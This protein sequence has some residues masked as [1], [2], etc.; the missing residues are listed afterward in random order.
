MNPGFSIE[1]AIPAYNSGRGIL[2]TLYSISRATAELGL[3]APSLVL[4]DSSETTDTVDAAARWAEETGASLRVDRS[5][6]RRGIKEATNVAFDLARADVLI[7]LDDDL[8]VT[9]SALRELIAAMDEGPRAEVAVG[10]AVPDPAYTGL[11]YRASAWQMQVTHRT[12]TMLPAGEFRAHGAYAG[13]RRSFYEKYRYPVGHGSPSNDVEMVGHLQEHSVTFLNVWRA[14]LLKVPAG[15]L[16]DFYTQTY[17][18]YAASGGSLPRETWH[19]RPALIEAAVDPIGALFYLFARG[20]C[21]LV[22]RR[23]IGDGPL[24]EL[25]EIPSTTKRF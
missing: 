21:V 10:S 9:T 1:F 15:T 13:M 3:G 12:A 14:A 2:P 4:S 7:T 6:R 16:R 24:G 19:L 22:G 23:R 20:W 18:A 11:R 25:W 5:E 17:R 8:V